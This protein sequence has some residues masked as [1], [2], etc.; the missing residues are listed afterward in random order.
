MYRL[1]EIKK[2]LSEKAA[3]RKRYTIDRKVIC[4]PA[5]SLYSFFAL[6]RLA[7]GFGE[8]GLLLLKG[9]CTP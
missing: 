1:C 5:V 2:L 9:R 8:E 6:T 3:Q 4:R 7:V